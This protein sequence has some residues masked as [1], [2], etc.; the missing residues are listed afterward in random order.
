MLVDKV[1]EMDILPILCRHW[2]INQMKPCSLLFILQ[3]KL[4]I[5]REICIVLQVPLLKCV[6]SR[7]Q[8]KF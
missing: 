7:F 6:C 5:K 4:K 8:G 2:R 3:N 1:I